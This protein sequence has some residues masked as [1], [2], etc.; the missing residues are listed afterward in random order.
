MSRASRW[1]VPIAA[2]MALPALVPH[3]GTG[4]GAGTLVAAFIT[5]TEILLGSDGRVVNSL[6]R[7][8][9]RDDWPKVHRLT[10]QTGLLTAGRD[11]PRLRDQFAAK[12]GSQ[13]PDAVSA[14]AT[15]LRGALEAEW[16]ALPPA[17]PGQPPAG[18]S[19]AA[20]AGF[21]AGGTPRLFYMDSASRPA[22]LLQPVALFGA[23]Q[24]L[25]VFA[26]A[27]NLEANEDV[28]ARLVRHLDAIAR[29]QPGGD[30]RR[31]MLMAFEAAKEELG[32]RNR[33]IGG[34]TFAAT[35]RP[36]EGYA[37]VR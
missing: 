25:E 34:A 23:G 28:S 12:L 4:Y 5:R 33:T 3:A 15:M 35:I 14:V 2:L 13:R 6:T 16:S 31:L 7:E 29:Q 26:I 21:D 10:D 36:G 9:L 32:A 8:T 30:R 37:P 18:R 20:V 19:F 27:S 24:E 22:F 1:A 17:G 11:L